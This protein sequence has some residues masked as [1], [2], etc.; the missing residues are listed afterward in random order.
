M[1]GGGPRNGFREVTAAE[2]YRWRPA[3]WDFGFAGGESMTT[4]PKR[5]TDPRGWW[6]DHSTGFG[7]A[8]QHNGGLL[9]DS[10]RFNPYSKYD[11]SGDRGSTWVTM[12]GNPRRYGRWEV[13]IRLRPFENAARDYRGKVELIP[14]D[15]RHYRCGGQNITVADLAAHSRKM[16]FGVKATRKNRQWAAT[17]RVGDIENHPVVVA[18]EVTKSHITW[19]LNSEPLGTVRN[20]A[21]VSDVPLTLRLTLQGSCDRE[22]NRTHAHFDFMRGYDLSRG[23]KVS[24]GGQLRATQFSGGC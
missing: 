12:H 7:R 8:N 21:A 6:S 3:L 17:R 1:A 9:L 18:A 2:K 19:F 16:R 10:Q 24:A 13:R 23:T 20:P 11:Y 4:P 15:E 5:G 22:M 14:A